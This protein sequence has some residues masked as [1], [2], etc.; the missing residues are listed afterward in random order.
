MSAKPSEIFL[1]SGQRLSRNDGSPQLNDAVE[2][3][4]VVAPNDRIAYDVLSG[5]DPQFRPLGHATLAQYEEAAAQLRAVVRG[6]STAWPLI[7][8]PGMQ[9]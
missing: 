8:A 7:V 1:I 5:I 9:G 3:R 6:E 4:V 2:Q